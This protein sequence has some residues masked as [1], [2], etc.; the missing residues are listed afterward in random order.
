MGLTKDASG[1]GHEVDTAKDDAFGFGQG[2]CFLGQ[3]ERVP[4]EVGVFYYLFPLI[5]MPK[6]RY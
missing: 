6:N 5:V 4:L 1:L 3:Q 2:R